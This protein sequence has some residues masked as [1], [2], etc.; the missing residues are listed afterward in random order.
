[1]LVLLYNLYSRIEKLVGL[2]V[3]LLPTI[4]GQLITATFTKNTSSRQVA[5]IDGFQKKNNHCLLYLVGINPLWPTAL[6][7][8]YVH[9]AFFSGNEKK[10]SF[11]GPGFDRFVHKFT[12]QVHTIMCLGIKTVQ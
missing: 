10:C 9:S 1:M 3:H 7:H 11:R 12:L 4:Y 8:C 5:F 2:H 6:I